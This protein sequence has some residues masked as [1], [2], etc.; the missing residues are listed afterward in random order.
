MTNCLA[1]L[2]GIN[3]GRAH[4]IAMADLR[5]LF[6]ELGHEDVR[7]LLNSGNVLFRSARPN[8]ARLAAGIETAISGRFG[9]AVPVIVIAAA[10]LAA[11]IQANPLRRV[12][13]DP[14]RHLVAFASGPGALARMRPLAQEAWAPEALAIGSKAAYLWCP[15]GILDSRLLKAFSRLAGESVTTRNWTTVLRLMEASGG[16]EP[17]RRRL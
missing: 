6:E 7:T 10:D 14:A 9:F 1:L 17:D 2:R 11:I 5:E 15:T 12:A 3:V 16:N 8:V 4:R 13:A